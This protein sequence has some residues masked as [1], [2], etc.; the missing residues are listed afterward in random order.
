VQAFR[1]TPGLRIPPSASSFAGAARS[2][3]LILLC[4][5][6]VGSW[7][8]DTV[9]V[10]KDSRVDVIEVGKP[11]ARASLL[12]PGVHRYVRYMIKDDARSE[13]D[14]WTRRLSYEQAGGRR[15][16]RIRQ[17][18]DAAD[19]S[20]VAIF[21]QTFD[22]ITF[23]PLGQVQTVTRG[24]KTKILAVTIDGSK[25]DSTADD[26]VDAAKPVHEKFDMRFFNFHTD[27]ELLQTLPWKRG[28]A[29]S[30][31]FYDVG[32][33]PPARYR[34]RVKGEGNLQGPDGVPIKCWVIQSESDDPKQP[35]TL[36]WFARRNQ[37][38]VREETDIPG[39]GILVK[40]LLNPEAH[41]G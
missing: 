22:P 40:T 5:F 29:A 36:F 24:A 15:I 41:D 16:L 31:P 1:I 32:L 20:Y 27:M 28:Y 3:G 14:L 11:L 19:K 6:S 7:A 35:P 13:I 38:L 39:Q 17:R 4:S 25:V 37:V 8:A 34:Y 21:D 23:E 12:V 9:P 33:D 30:I 18:W 10:A 26:G 2:L